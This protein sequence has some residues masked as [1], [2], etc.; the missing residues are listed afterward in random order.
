MIVVWGDGEIV[1]ID[2]DSQ[3]YGPLTDGEV[4]ELAALLATSTKIAFILQRLT[5][6]IAEHRQAGRPQAAANASAVFAGVVA[7][8]R[9]AM[10]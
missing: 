4:D 7:R 8:T 9:S 3:E 2:N 1:E 5:E 10:H 6:H